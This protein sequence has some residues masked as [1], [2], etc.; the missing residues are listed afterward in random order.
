MIAALK[1]FTGRNRWVW[2]A[3]GVFLLWLAL[4]LVTERFSIHSL[5]GVSVS[6]SFLLLVAIGQMLVI[7]IGR[8]NIDLSIPSVVTLTAYL[9]VIVS[10][11]QDARLPLT[12]VVLLGVGLAIG[13]LNAFLVVVLRI[14]AIIATLA[15]GYGLATATLLANR[16]VKTMA[17]ADFLSLLSTG[18]FL[19]VPVI[20]ILSVAAT[21]IAA[22]V[23][24]RLGY[25]R[26]LSAIGQSP[27][28][29]YLAGVRVGKTMTIAFIAS[30]LLATFAGMLLSAYS[31][32]AFLEMGSPYL[33]QSIGAVVLGGTL[34]AGGS[35][36]AFGT[37]FGALLL[38]LIVTTM[39]IAGLPAGA[40]DIVQGLVII[41]IMAVA[42]SSR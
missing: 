34:I 10:S 31:G 23:L 24:R 12:F 18:R 8:G 15:S 33:L 6:A 29:A 36:T 1:N 41:A 4:S 27:D 7:T 13:L 21:V 37:L 28:A 42:G 26:Q 16:Q 2:A 32:G 5:A 9:T 39:Q 22:L 30:A 38:V 40:Q 11:G 17:T 20:L 35:A 14:P 25:G 19:G 3:F